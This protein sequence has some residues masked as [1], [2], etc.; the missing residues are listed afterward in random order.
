[1]SFQILAAIYFLALAIE[2]F[3]NLTPSTPLQYFS[4]PS[5]MLILLVYYV[6]NTR[7][8]AAGLKYPI[9]FAL[10]FSWFGDVLLLIDK[11]TKSL[12]VY[13]LIAFLIAHLFYIVYFWKIRRANKIEKLPNVL[14]FMA[15]AAYSLSLF[16]FIAPNVKNLL[17]PV[18]VYALVISTM[19]GAS[20]AAFDFGKQNFGKI[21]V[22]G[23]LFFIVS[24]SILA[25]N[26]FAAPFEYA[27]VFVM[28]TYA[29]AQLLIVEGSLQNLRE[30][31]LTPRRQDA[32]AQS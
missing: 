22:A 25:I 11:Q 26:R 29:L 2:L 23:T 8:L 13:G 27:P 6:F 7:K 28:L 18:A 3:A 14:I 12:F 30:I 10:V 5:L 1:M 4:K 32:E 16:A 19:L 20:L 15:V 21:C 31:N 9:I 24:D 17:V